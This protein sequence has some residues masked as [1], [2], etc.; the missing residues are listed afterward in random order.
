MRE[1]QPRREAQHEHPEAAQHQLAARSALRARVNA[2]GGPSV[3]VRRWSNP[4]RVVSSHRFLDHI[5][6]SATTT[7]KIGCFSV[8][9]AA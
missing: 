2:A 7:H 3:V 5:F 9:T 8:P 4:D 1:Y 6:Y